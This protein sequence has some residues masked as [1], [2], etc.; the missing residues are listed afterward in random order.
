MAHSFIFLCDIQ[1]HS[2]SE[3]SEDVEAE[4]MFLPMLDVGFVLDKIFHGGKEILV[5]LRVT[6]TDWSILRVR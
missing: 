2:S 1:T 4:V 5:E 3:N 6:S